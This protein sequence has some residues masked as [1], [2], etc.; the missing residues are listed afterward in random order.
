M[1]KI[2]KKVLFIDV[3]SHECQEIKALTQSSIYLA[4]IYLKRYLLNWFVKGLLVPSTSEFINFLKIRNELIK[5]VDFSFVAIEP[6]WRHFNN[7]IYKKLNNVF[8]FGLQK[9]DNNFKI[10]YL[11]FKSQKKNDQGA[12]LFKTPDHINLS[13]AIPV[14]DTDYFCRNVL[15]VILDKYDH[16][17]S[18]K[19]FL[20][21]NCEG[22]E[23]DVI[24]S[25]N[26]F[27]SK[28]LAGILGSLDDVEKKKGAIKAND[29]ENYLHLN[30]INFCKFSSNM[31]TWPNAIRFLKNKLK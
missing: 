18:P 14:L 23:D 3:G 25:V 16:N 6:N 31:S 11:S 13:E 4:I 30:T 10:K 17:Q 26:K 21:L 12:S 24:Y 28:Q 20:R 15:Q 9:M 22:T 19:M 2:K 29:L 27:F 8:S 1:E 7:K 5:K